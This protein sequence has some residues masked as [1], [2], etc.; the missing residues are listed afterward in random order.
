MGGLLRRKRQIAAKVESV[1]GTAETLAA[2]DANLLVYEP[3]VTDDIPLFE[4]NPARASL[5]PL[6][7]IPGV[8]M[9]KFSF[10]VDLKG[11]SAIGTAPSYGKLLRA[12]GMKETAVERLT[13]GAITGGPFQH[14]ETI[15]GGTSA[16]TA[17]VIK[18][19]ANGVTT[20]Y[21][22]DRVGTFTAGS[23]TITGGTSGATA[24]ETGG[25]TASQGFDYTTNSV[26][27][28]IPTL[29]MASYEDGIIKKA[30]GARGSMKLSASVGEPGRLEFEFSAVYD[31]TSDGS[32]LSGIT[33]ESTVPEPYLSAGLVLG[34]FSPVFAS[35]EADL[36]NTVA[37][38]ENANNASGILSALITDRKP[39][40]TIDPEMELIAT[41][42]W[43]TEWINKTTQY[44]ETTFG[45]AAGN[46]VTI[47]APTLQLTSISDGSRTEI[48]VATLNVAMKTSSNTGEDEFTILVQ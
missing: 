14:G 35:I 34:S 38:R 25:T 8:K 40:G 31:S 12:C 27:S 47:I 10:A 22:K 16:A 45:S 24:T 11:S 7:D 2:A 36:G 48:A 20:L 30:R 46:K 15:T 29:T 19:T 3:S 5:S 33:Y 17:K 43:F 44:F 6:V 39:V 28:N 21:M 4:R 13:I 9:R 1:E 37:M 41:K 42:D 32:L 26:L 23:E 18:R